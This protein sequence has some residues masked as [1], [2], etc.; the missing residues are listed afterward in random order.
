[1]GVVRRLSE[2]T[3]DTMLAGK[4]YPVGEIMEYAGDENRERITN[5]EKK[6]LDKMGEEL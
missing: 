6:A 2:L 1:M 4:N 5:A 3:V